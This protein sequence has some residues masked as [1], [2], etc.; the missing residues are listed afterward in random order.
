[1]FQHTARLA[2]EKADIRP[3]LPLCSLPAV[4]GTQMTKT[5]YSELLRDPRWQRVRLQNLEAAGWRCERCDDA[6]TTLHVHHKHYI[7]GRKPWEYSQAELVVLC[8][9]CHEY[10]HEDKDR[11]STLMAHLDLD[12][13]TSAE[14]FIAYGAG[15]V[16]FFHWLLDESFQAILNDVQAQKPY[17]FSLGMVAA[18]LGNGPFLHDSMEPLEIQILAGALGSNTE[19]QADFLALLDKHDIRPLTKK[20]EG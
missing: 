1:M 13:P 15:A 6:E 16:Y 3:A 7:K 2:T 5:T 11:R 18:A 8:A 20:A 4:N 14:D 9:P 10:E 19:F 17:Q 12:G